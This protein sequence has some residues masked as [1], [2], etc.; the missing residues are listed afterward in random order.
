MYCMLH[1]FE[2]GCMYVVESIGV[3]CSSFT[4][5]NSSQSHSF[6]SA[7][8][9]PSGVIFLNISQ[10]LKLTTV[11]VEPLQLPFG[12]VPLVVQLN[13]PGYVFVKSIS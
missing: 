10:S 11:L 12:S 6:R 13:V 3:S 5:L 1:R 4:S 7:S 8:M 2:Y 9:Y